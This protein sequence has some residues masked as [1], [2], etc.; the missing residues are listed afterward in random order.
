MGLVIVDLRLNFGRQKQLVPGFLRYLPYEKNGEIVI[1]AQ[2]F[3]HLR[4]LHQVLY[5]QT[6]HGTSTTR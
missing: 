4:I 2:L 1:Q 5:P 3:F 6:P